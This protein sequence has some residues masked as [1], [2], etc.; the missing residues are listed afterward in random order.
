[1]YN[2]LSIFKKLKEFDPFI[3]YRIRNYTM[4][5]LDR[6]LSNPIQYYTQLAD[7]CQ[8]FYIV[9]G[10]FRELI[11][12]YV[13]PTLC[14]WTVNTRVTH[15]NFTK[16]KSKTTMQSDRLEKDFITFASRAHSLNLQREF[17]R[18]L[19][20]VHLE[21]IYFGYWLEEGNNV[22]LFSLPTGWCVLSGKANGNW[23]FKLN[24]SRIGDRDIQKLP[25][26]IASLVRRYKGK[27]G[28]EALAPVEFNKGFCIKY[29][30]HIPQ[31]IP[32]FIYVVQLVIDL[33]KEKQ[34]GLL[35]SE[36]DVTNL[37]SM[38]IPHNDKEHDDILFSDPIIKQYAEGLTDLLG[39]G[40]ALLPSPMKLGVLPTTKSTAI[41]KNSVKNAIDNFG[42]ETNMP[43][44]GGAN[45]GAE[46]KRAIEFA[47]AKVF[48]LLDQIS[49]VINLKMKYDGYGSGNGY[50]FQYELLH[51]TSF[52]E[53]EVIER[54]LKQAQ[55]GAINKF[56]LEAAR[57]NDPMAVLG[58]H[59]LENVLYRDMWESAVLPL[60]SHTR[61]SDGGRP[62]L[63]DDD[64]T[65][66]GEQTR[67]D[68]TNNP[69]N[70]A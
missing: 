45:S 58:Q 55:A 24:T 37:I 44:F 51:M 16:Q 2:I 1:M 40:N 60:S 15:P 27:T 65:G 7:I 52:N 38:E 36:N 68:D 41:D 42:E 23:T 30:D 67:T 4:D 64:L 53:E 48:S 35:R 14:R 59:Y 50:E 66:A 63:D 10:F 26:E 13:D 20:R 70:R 6:F 43:S 62:R 9:G 28:D 18:I 47:S 54:L 29:S 39:D 56:T 25:K 12:Y 69:A 3:D 61:S 31:I 17:K 8:H 57:G 46:L 11:Q 21:D 32:P 33:I 19:L 34:L 22:S 5:D 49:S